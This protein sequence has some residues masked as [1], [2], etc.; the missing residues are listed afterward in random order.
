MPEVIAGAVT[1]A[2][3][4]VVVGPVV[5][6]IAGFGVGSR[7]AK[8]MVGAKIRTTSKTL[9]VGDVQSEKYLNYHIGKDKNQVGHLKLIENAVPEKLSI[10]FLTDNI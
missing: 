10:K 5:G 2:A 7:V 9:S 6:A 8:G 1:A 4:S 3:I